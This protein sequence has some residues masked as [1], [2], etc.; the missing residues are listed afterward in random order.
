[1]QKEQGNQRQRA[2]RYDLLVALDEALAPDV[3]QLQQR[4]DQLERMF[5]AWLDVPAYLRGLFIEQ[6][7]SRTAE[8][9][10]T[11]DKLLQAKHWSWTR[12]VAGYSTGAMFM[13]E[14]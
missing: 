11:R 12:R 8:M 14:A 5:A 3:G 13:G 2:D 7:A 9:E 6:T 10:A 1:M 4:A